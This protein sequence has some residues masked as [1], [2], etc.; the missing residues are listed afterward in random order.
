MIK[1]LNPRVVTSTLPQSFSANKIE[2]GIHENTKKKNNNKQL[3]PIQKI[4]LQARNQAVMYDGICSIFCF[5]TSLEGF[6]QMTIKA[7]Y[8]AKWVV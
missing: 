5:V 4:S 7:A 3:S 2:R 6:F 1:V 8:E